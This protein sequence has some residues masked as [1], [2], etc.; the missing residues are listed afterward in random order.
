MKQNNN[1][2]FWLSYVDTMTGMAVLFLI[3][4]VAFLVRARKIDEKSETIIS[5]WK[6]VLIELNAMNAAP[7]PDTLLGGIRITLADNILF[8]LNSA[9][10][11]Y[12][13]K[14]KIKQISQLI[15]N[16]LKKNT[17]Y[18]K[19]LRIEVGGHTDKSGND[20]IN[21]PLSYNRSYSVSSV[22]K[23]VFKNENLDL[24]I[25]RNIGYGSKYPVPGTEK[26]IIAPINR[27][28]TIT[29]QLIST[30]LLN[31]EKR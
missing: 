21:F 5:D 8:N 16:F 4:F 12:T 17:N 20:T 3:L 26:L 29:L 30:E 23:E 22:M 25:I 14:Q 18:I 11:S 1:Y 6:Q 9:E 10:L 24:N 13:G 19:S 28:V 31:L 27:R 15:A 2:G 7:I